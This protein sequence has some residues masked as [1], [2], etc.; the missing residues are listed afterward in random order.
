[1]DFQLWLSFVFVVVAFFI[2]ISKESISEFQDILQ[3]GSCNNW[4]FLL[5][6]SV[7]VKEFV[8][9]FQFVAGIGDE[10]R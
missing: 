10:F 2:R 8:E 6:L 9:F 3:P 7:D 5:L 1:M 4:W